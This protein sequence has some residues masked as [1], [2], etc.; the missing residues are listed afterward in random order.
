MSSLA[1]KLNRIKAMSPAE[2]LF[3]AY[4]VFQTKT[5]KRKVSRGWQPVPNTS[6][7]SRG[8]LFAGESEKHIAQWRRQFSSEL[9]DYEPLLSGEV[10]LFGHL[11]V[12]LGGEVNWHKDPESKIVAPLVFGKDIDYRDNEQVGNCKT[13]WEL[14]RHAHLVPLAVAYAVTG[15]KR[16]AQLVVSQISSWVEQNPFGLGV[17]WCSSLEVA[18]R[19]VAWSLVH[20]LFL[21]RDEQGLFGWVGASQDENTL[22]RCIYQHVYF[23]QNY[24]SRHSSANNHL[25]GELTGVWVGCRV[26]NLGYQGEE[27]AKAAKRELEQEAVK[28]V[29]SDGV[30][31][32]QAN[33]YHLWVMEYLCFNWLVGARF[34][35]GFSDTFAKRIS[36]MASFIN[37]VRPPGGAVPQIGDSDD[38]VVARFTPMDAQDPYSEV[39]DAITRLM[40]A[41]HQSP[42][43][44]Q[45][46]FWYDAITSQRLP[47][48]SQSQMTESQSFPEGGYAILRSADAHLIFDAGSLG[49]PSIAAHGHADAL[50]FSLALNGMFWLVDPGTYC[51]HTQPDWRDYFRSTAAHNTI[52]INGASQSMMG[53]AFLWLQHAQQS[54]GPLQQTSDE[55]VISGKVSG[56]QDANILH[57]RRVTLFGQQ[58]RLVVEDTISDSANLRLF[59]HFHPDVCVQAGSQVASFKAVCKDQRLQ[60]NVDSALS[61]RVCRG[62]ENPHLGWYSESL[63]HREPIDVLVGEMKTTGACK[64]LTEFNWG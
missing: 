6:V 56:Y 51:Y 32:E 7:V 53:G 30:N 12:N 31:K 57:S 33:Y 41:N 55:V 28:Q 50:S 60:V 37:A 25:I 1:W 15:D 52:E 17:H 45:K 63:G 13:L 34:E 35:D 19:L 43:P 9:E 61:W 4:R 46:A 24:L 3:R 54:M 10:N 18:L 22:G 44:C 42:A 2:I 38:G 5:E 48:L 64:I 47:S 26:F 20:S 11:L 39:T 27:W 29:F 8:S 58:K 21:L 36:S 40:D 16:Y 14:S 23:I 49:Y 59:Y 62:E